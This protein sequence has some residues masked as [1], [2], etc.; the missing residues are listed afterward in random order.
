M[1]ERVTLGGQV[2]WR[3][4]GGVATG[5]FITVDALTLPGD[6]P[7]QVHVWAPD[8]PVTRIVVAFDGDTAF[9]PGGVAHATWDMARSAAE[10][11]GLA[12]IAIV[13]RERDRE[14][15]HVDWA[16]GS[17]PYGDL[18]THAAWAANAVLPFV[19]AALGWRVP[20]ARAAVVGSSHGGLAAFWTATRHPDRF[21]L[22]GCLSPSFFSGLG[23]EDSLA[24]SELVAPV[25]DVLRSGG[26][27]LWVDWGERR[28]GGPHNAV[29]ERLAAARGREIVRLL[30]GWGR[31]SQRVTRDVGPDPEA[32]GWWAQ[33]AEH[34]HDERAWRER[35]RWMLA[36]FFGDGR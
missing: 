23:A 26:V 27:R 21:A 24:D 4:R 5:A 15:T 35:F 2:A 20:A 11:P 17:R 29:V 28:D 12:V 6:A 36:A 14:Y 16:L 13:P 22:A 19:Q 33:V 7:H 3:H 32:P 9:W 34:G 30:A 10:F 25:V 1:S 18:P 31:P 8:E